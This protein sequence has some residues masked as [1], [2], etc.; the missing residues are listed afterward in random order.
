[1]RLLLEGIYALAAC[2]A[3]GVVFRLSG[4]KLFWAALGGALGWLSF[5]FAQRWLDSDIACYFL[6]TVVIS[7]YA[8]YMARRF[9]APASI[10]LVI[11]LIPLVPGGG[12]YDTMEACM[13]G[14][15]GE[16]AKT[17]LHTIGIA[18]ALAVGIV[19]VSSTVRLLNKRRCNQD[20]NE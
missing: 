10:Y 17:G 3:F 13:Q 18:G 4:G 8:E 5:R 6:A 19:L 12:I 1:M 7:G 16:A 2:L 11:S 15:A 9:Q 14:L 20:G